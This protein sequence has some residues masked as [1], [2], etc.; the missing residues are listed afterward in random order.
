MNNK[1]F[2]ALLFLPAAVLATVMIYYTAMCNFQRVEVAVQGYDPKDFLSGYYMNLQPNWTQTDCNQFA[3]HVCPIRE[4]KTYYRYYINRKQS[5]K[6]TEDVN[7]G[8]VKLVFSYQKGKVPMV[9]DLL[10][11]GRSYFDYIK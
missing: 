4:F 3:D 10:V 11:D 8:S 2:Y 9:V 6:L 7:A 5:N 1:I